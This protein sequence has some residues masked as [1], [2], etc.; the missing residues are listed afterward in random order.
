MNAT[1]SG[2]APSRVDQPPSVTISTTAAE[3][4]RSTITTRRASLDDAFLRLGCSTR[5]SSSAMR[6]DDSAGRERRAPLAPRREE[7]LGADLAPPAGTVARAHCWPPASVGICALW[8]EGSS[9]VCDRSYAADSGV[10][11]SV[12][13]QGLRPHEERVGSIAAPSEAQSVHDQLERAQPAL[14]PPVATLHVERVH[15]AM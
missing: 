4:S 12:L 13:G 10:E 14:R 6:R 7:L 3:A 1:C 2:L 8:S 15:W 9:A 5:T 11:S